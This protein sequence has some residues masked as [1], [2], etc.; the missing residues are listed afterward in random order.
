MTRDQETGKG[1]R[2]HLRSVGGH[3]HD[4]HDHDDHGHDE[5]GHDEH[6]HDHPH[7]HPH[8]AAAAHDHPHPHGEH[9]HDHP[10][11]HGA[12]EHPESLAEAV[13][14]L[15]HLKGELEVADMEVEAAKAKAEGYLAALQRERAEFQNFKRRTAEDRDRELGLASEGLLRK[16]LSVTDDFDRAIEAMPAE[17]RGNGWIDG[18]ALLDRKLRALLESEGV[19]PIEAMG[20]PFDPYEHEVVTNVPG[21]GRPHGEVVAELQKGYRLRD[22]I[23]RPAMVAVADGADAAGSGGSGKPPVN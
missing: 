15:N 13:A 20:K 11:P 12:G 7:P 4:G 10:H 2:P 21:T 23:L 16:L 1:T 14:Q 19:T 8:A 3:G 18:I 6:G 17:L 22:R 9:G 5:H